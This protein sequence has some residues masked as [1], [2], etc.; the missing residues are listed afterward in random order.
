MIKSMTILD[1]IKTNLLSH[2]YEEAIQLCQQALEVE[3]EAG[4]P[5]GF[6]GQIIWWLG[7]AYL[8]NDELEEAESAWLSALISG[9]Y[10]EYDQ[11]EKELLNFLEEQISFFSQHRFIYWANTVQQA[12]EK[13]VRAEDEDLSII[14]PERIYYD[15]LIALWEKRLKDAAY[16]F[17]LVLEKEP[18]HEDAWANLAEVYYESELIS[19]AEEAIQKAILINPNKFS[20]QLF[21]G[22]V[23]ERNRDDDLAISH[24]LKLFQSH[25]EQPE[26]C[27]RLAEIYVRKCQHQEAIESIRKGISSCPHDSALK[28]RLANLLITSY[29]DF[30]DDALLLEAQNCCQE[31][32][33]VQSTNGNA[34]ACLGA[35][36]NSFQD[37]S[38]SHLYFGRAAYYHKNYQETIEYLTNLAIKP[39]LEPSDYEILMNSYC[40][41]NKHE[42][43]E[44]LCRDLIKNA[45][46]NFDFANNNF[47]AKLIYILNDAEKTE[48]ALSFYSEI[49]ESFPDQILAKRIKNWLL[50]TIYK[51]QAEVEFY[52]Q[53]FTDA[54]DNLIKTDV[55]E[56]SKL[57][58]AIRAVS[59]KSNFLLNYQ[60]KDDKLL[61]T[62]YAYF[63]YD[64]L[65]CKSPQFFQDLSI[66]NSQNRKLKIG[67]ISDCFFRHTVG[68]L[69][70]GWIKYADH[71]DFEVYI[72]HLNKKS[73]SQTQQ[74][75]LFSDYFH[76]CQNLNIEQIAE[77]VLSDQLDILVFLDVG[78]TPEMTL[79]SSM[80]LAPIQCV[81][82]GHPITTGSP[83]IDYFLSSDLMEPEY[84][85][86]H[87]TETLVRLPNISIAYTP[88]ALPS[89]CKQRADFGLPE[90]K[91][92]YFSGQSLFKYLPKYDSAFAEI[93]SQVP[94]S[95][96]LF[97]ALPNSAQT[98]RFHQ[99]LI[100]VFTSYDPSLAERIILLPRLNHID[101]LSI[102]LISD[103]GLDSF[104]WSG[105]K[106]SLDAVHTCLPLVTY[107]G[108]FMR[109]R[110]AYGILRALG[111]E[112]T[113]ASSPAD[114]CAKAIRLGRDAGYRREIAEAM[115]RAHGNLFDDRQAVAALEQFYREAVAQKRRA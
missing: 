51:D 100:K 20:Y 60:G 73:D 26:I 62:K 91:I 95:L 14:S 42:E 107:P 83:T 4:E 102:N 25:G 3:E 28:L 7:L 58:D 30:G 104:A 43:A 56:S 37:T 21:L 87:Y 79:L 45:P 89:Q 35:I 15:G 50:P 11:W 36:A 49:E 115:F 109:G 33:R 114:Y 80:R 84:G 44:E 101:Y 68:T 97:I 52:R 77:I 10:E 76:S 57:E 92:L 8:F 74:Y 64:L 40:Y 93:L 18:E 53:H 105:G 106:T 16:S 61:Q 17:W 69:F 59:Y 32:L 111:V 6:V 1:Q 65:Q 85:Q 88:H 29:S 55:D 86:E 75:Q 72:Y 71:S 31:V 78:M 13:L 34:L 5:S 47:Y 113:I 94:D 99:R 103:V 96:L 90:D 66:Q 9:F 39:L 48:E 54:L 82:W 12:K 19:K 67:Y 63:V 81:T 112:E 38:R 110:H 27:S 70:L 108:E 41:L 23:Y 46:N 98:E 24:Y 22:K 2:H